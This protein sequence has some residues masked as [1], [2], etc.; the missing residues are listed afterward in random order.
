MK[1]PFYLALLA[2]ALALSACQNNV[3]ETN[4]NP[5]SEPEKATPTSADTTPK[6]NDEMPKKADAVQEAPKADDNAGKDKADDNAGKDKA[7]DNAEADKEDNEKSE[8]SVQEETLHL[9]MPDAVEELPQTCPQSQC[10]QSAECVSGKCVCNGFPMNAAEATTWGCDQSWHCTET[11]GCIFEGKSVKPFTRIEVEFVEAVPVQAAVETEQALDENGEAAPEQAAHANVDDKA[12]KKGQKVK[13]KSEK[14]LAEEAEKAAIEAMQVLQEV[15]SYRI[16]EEDN[17]KCGGEKTPDEDLEDR[18]YACSNGQWVCNRWKGCRCGSEE[19]CHGA[20]VQGK[21]EQPKYT[22]SS[23]VYCKEGNCPCGDGFCAQNAICVAGMCQCGDAK[24]VPGNNHALVSNQYGQ[25]TCSAL[26]DDYDQSLMIWACVQNHGCVTLDGRH[27]PKYTILHDDRELTLCTPSKDDNCHVLE[28][29]R[30]LDFFSGTKEV[31]G[32]IQPSPLAWYHVHGE[33]DTTTATPGVY[34]DC[35]ISKEQSCESEDKSVFEYHGTSKSMLPGESGLEVVYIQALNVKK[36]EG[37]T[38]YCHGRDNEPIAAPAVSDGY[39][40][41]KVNM[42]PPSVTEDA[43]PKIVKGAKG[44]NGKAKKL[45]VV[46]KPVIPPDEDIRAWVCDDPNGCSCGEGK[47]PQTGICH[48]EKCTYNGHEIWEGYLCS[49]KG[50]VC[51]NESCQCGENSCSKNMMCD[52]SQCTC[53]G[54]LKPSGGGYECTL[55]S[56]WRCRN[57]EGCQCGEEPCSYS[58]SCEGDV[59]LCDGHPKPGR[60]FVCQTDLWKCEAEECSCFGVST[61]RGGVCDTRICKGHETSRN[62]ECYCGLSKAISNYACERAAGR[63]ENVCENVAGCPCAN[64]TCPYQ[65]VCRE[66]GTCHDRTTLAPLLPANRYEL[67]SGIAKCTQD[68]GCACGTG[69][70]WCAKDKYCIAGKAEPYPFNKHYRN[71]LVHFDFSRIEG[72][73]EE[74]TVELKNTALNM[75][76]D[77]TSIPCNGY[78]M[79]SDISHYLCSYESFKNENNDMFIRPIGWLCD[80]EKGCPCGD[81]RCRMGAECRS[82]QVC[83]SSYIHLK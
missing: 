12:E 60:N 19:A 29:S 3:P 57:E 75:I 21:C 17:F 37:G 15:K 80:S 26:E 49:E 35:V 78:T 2:G 44:K 30:Y 61:H 58:S 8:D 18:E 77:E 64:T 7:D 73:D 63:Y 51:Q 22:P 32:K 28:K 47:C 20:C 33:T 27:Y 65:T 82:N 59:C 55:E 13:P 71:K 76:Y 6:A 74:E 39:V 68:G 52:G 24:S 4:N 83:A 53:N 69:K 9:I 62:N 45:E 43:A 31:E 5:P 23:T 38:R 42:L 46:V 81:T 10:P 54:F 56:G 34:G 50:C 41:K 25:F 66:G 36:C 40:C 70:G 79:P 14:Q 72:R 48:Q 1:T 67:N 16:V 11:N